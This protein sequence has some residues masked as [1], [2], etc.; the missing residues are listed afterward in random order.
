MLQSGLTM[1]RLESIGG[2]VE[3]DLATRGKAPKTTN[4]QPMLLASNSII[5]DILKTKSSD[6]VEV[7]KNEND[8]LTLGHRSCVVELCEDESLLPLI[9]RLREAHGIKPPKHELIDDSRFKLSN[10]IEHKYWSKYNGIHNNVL[11]KSS[12]L[13][14]NNSAAKPG[15]VRRKPIDEFEFALF[16]FENEIK[17]G[18]HEWNLKNL[19]IR[20]PALS[21]KS[22]D[23][24]NI[25]SLSDNND[26][27]INIENKQ[28]EKSNDVLTQNTGNFDDAYAPGD[29]QEIL[30]VYQRMDAGQSIGDDAVHTVFKSQQTQDDIRD[31]SNDNVNVGIAA[32]FDGFDAY[33]NPPS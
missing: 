31:E 22:N 9:R 1:D 11:P 5:F 19:E 6:P 21:N 30:A 23:N 29:T 26:N 16:I 13:N 28:D 12:I 32:P 33:D 20:F 25:D 10:C 24:I 14:R 17:C 3:T 8:L 2:G 4:K 15:I 27:N 18:N 7:S